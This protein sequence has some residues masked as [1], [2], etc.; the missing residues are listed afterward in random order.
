[1]SDIVIVGHRTVSTAGFVVT[2]YS[3]MSTAGSPDVA[4]YDITENS[5]PDDVAVKINVNVT[6]AA[7]T[8]KAKEAAQNIAAAVATIIAEAQKLPPNTPIQLPNGTSTT[9][10]QLLSDIQ[11]TKFV[12]TDNSNFGNGGVGS[13][14]RATMT[15]TLYYASFAEGTGRPSYTNTVWSGQGVIATI[16]H[17]LGHLSA[18]GAANFLSENSKFNQEMAARKIPHAAGDFYSL[19]SDYAKDNEAF[20]HGYTL[21]VSAALQINISTYDT[22]VTTNNYFGSYAGAEAIYLQHQQDYGF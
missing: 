20:A 10:G 18:Q 6:N 7:N 14:D 5:S 2:N 8:E 1:M 21:A 3:M 9:A 15:D 4:S 12:V 13:A 16:L 17:E 11:A 19:G 22:L